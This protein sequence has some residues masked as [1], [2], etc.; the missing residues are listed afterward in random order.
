[1]V[2]GGPMPETK[3]EVAKTDSSNAHIISVLVARFES[4][5]LGI[6]GIKVNLEQVL[7]K[8]ALLEERWAHTENHCPYRVKVARNEN[9]VARANV[10]AQEALDVAQRAVDLTVENRVDIA[11]LAIAASGG[12]G[13]GGVIGATIMYL[14]ST[15]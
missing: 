1:M 3:S 15:L 4:M 6:K 14:V 10:R 2:I 8:I 9:G 12:G 5:E 11:K 7:I 13:L